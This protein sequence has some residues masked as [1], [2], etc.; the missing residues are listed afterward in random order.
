MSHCLLNF[1]KLE[2]LNSWLCN[3][4]SPLMNENSWWRN[5]RSSVGC[6]GI[7]PHSECSPF[8]V[9]KR[10]YK[11]FRRRVSI[12]KSIFLYILQ[13]NSILNYVLIDFTK[14]AAA[15][16][17]SLL[18][19]ILSYIVFFVQWYKTGPHCEKF[20]Q[21]LAKFWVPGS[22]YSW[23]IRVEGGCLGVKHRKLWNVKLN[24]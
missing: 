13:K 14:C 22:C 8:T 15:P 9:L 6:R 23:N 16:L 4:L 10:H 18:N 19:C 5:W 1:H 3:I 20:I 24:L 17:K 11:Q 2:L 7:V 21:I 12:V